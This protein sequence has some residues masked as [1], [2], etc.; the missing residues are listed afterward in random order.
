LLELRLLLL[1]Y[2]SRGSRLLELLWL[3][4]LLELL[5]L[6]LLLWSPLGRGAAVAIAE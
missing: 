2:K 5:L 6:E 3:W 4:L 1:G